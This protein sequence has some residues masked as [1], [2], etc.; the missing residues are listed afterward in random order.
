MVRRGRQKTEL[1]LVEKKK[2][3]LVCFSKR[4]T[5]LFKKARELSTLSG[6]KIGAIIFSPADKL[7][8][9]E[10]PTL[11]SLLGC[12][13]ENESDSTTKSEFVDVTNGKEAPFWWNIP[14]VE[15]MSYEE[16]LQFQRALLDYSERKFGK[17]ENFKERL[18]QAKQQESDERIL[19]N[20]PTFYGD[21]STD[22]KLQ[23]DTLSSIFD[24]TL[25]FDE[26]WLQ[27][28]DDWLMEA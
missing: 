12:L 24:P 10:A 14:Q 7:Y 28:V 20:P 1:K 4:R 18:L 27:C 6:A 15:A 19:L 17:F 13:N 22:P 23:M 11:D 21:D 16:L 9:M 5:G 2:S 25:S 8:T 26:Q 3:R